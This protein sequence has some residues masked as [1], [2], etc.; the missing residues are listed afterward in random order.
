MQFYDL[1]GNSSLSYKEF[2][3]FILPCDKSELREEVCQRKTYDIDLKQGKRLHPSVA[4]SMAD[5]FEAEV[6]C[7][8]KLEML[9]QSLH[10][11]PG[12][13]TQAAFAEIDSQNQG[14][15]SHF[16]LYGF[17]NLHGFDATDQELIAMVRRIEGRGNGKVDYDEFVTAI[18]P[19]IVRMHDIQ[20]EQDQGDN[21][22]QNKM[23][24]GF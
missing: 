5:Y 14:E 6:N 21:L 4:E 20:Q 24:Y 11:C 15:V 2:L 13:N 10:R 22:A 12:W 19:I 1:D 18:D 9:K 17:L 3:K 8:L 23:G 7:H 16:N